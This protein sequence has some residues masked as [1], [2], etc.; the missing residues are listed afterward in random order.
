MRECINAYLNKCM[1][2]SINTLITKRMNKYINTIKNWI[3]QVNDLL[4]TIFVFATITGLLFNDPFKVISNIS[5]L[6]VNLGTNGIAGLIS[7]LII[8]LWYRR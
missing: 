3:S 1:N 6:L 5:N 8:V 4:I 2:E 7:L